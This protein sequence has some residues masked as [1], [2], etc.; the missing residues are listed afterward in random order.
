[1]AL[2]CLAGVIW[3]G[4]CEER[5]VRAGAL[6]TNNSRARCYRTDYAE[7]KSVADSGATIEVAS[8]SGAACGFK[9]ASFTV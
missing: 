1:M 6:A 7:T 9:L 3:A 8:S 4:A 5:V 2:N